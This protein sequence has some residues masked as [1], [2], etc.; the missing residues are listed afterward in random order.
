MI[1]PKLGKGKPSQTQ[2]ELYDAG[3]QT[4]CNE[5][6]KIRSRLDFNIGSRGWC[7]ILEQQA[8]LLKS[9]FDDA[10]KLIGDCRKKGLLPLDIC[11]DDEARSF[12]CEEALDDSDIYD[13][14]ESIVSSALSWW[15]DYTG[16]SFWENQGFYVQMLVE[17][18]DLR[19]L[20]EPVCK[21]YRVRLANA[22]GWADISQRADLLRN[23]KQWEA[24]GKSCV[25][26]Y[27]GDHDPSGLAITEHLRHTLAELSP[28]VGWNP[29]NLI[30]ERFGLNSDFIAS[31]GLSWIDNLITGSGKDLG[32]SKHPDHN[33]PYVQ[34]YLSKYGRRKCEANALV[35]APELGRQLC[36]DAIRKYISDEA[37]EEYEEQI[38]QQRYEVKEAVENRFKELFA[39]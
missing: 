35:T 12:H 32:D 17:K 7:Y 36:R 6:M 20:F 16:S 10:Q 28:A 22:R 18:M 26:L 5:I 19:S 33:K 8:G 23:F 9:D 38:Q 3:I 25:L 1:I 34:D 24:R 29:E 30:I 39:A 27:C 13:E 2:R 4:F 11:K 37:I 31:A 21:E 15:E 14:A